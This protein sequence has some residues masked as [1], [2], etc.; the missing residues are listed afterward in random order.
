MEVIF[1]IDMKPKLANALIVSPLSSS[2]KM[3]QSNRKPIL[4]TKTIVCLTENF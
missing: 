2:L 1:S 4:M 3:L